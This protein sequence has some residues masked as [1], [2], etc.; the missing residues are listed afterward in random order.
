MA[1][2]AATGALTA[3]ALSGPLSGSGTA[4]GHVDAP[5]SV[6]D[7]AADLTDVYAFTSP[8]NHDT[9]TLVAS[10]RPFQLPATAGNA[11]VDYPF[12]NG[13][14]YEIHTDAD[15]DG[16]ADTTY[17]WT[18]RTKDSR[19]PFPP[20]PKVGPEPV[21]SLSSSSLRVRQTYTLE[22]VRAGK[23]EKL[24]S[25]TAAPTHAGRFLMPNYAG[26]R[27]QA[28][29]KLPGGGQTV[30]AQS[31]DAFKANTQAFGLYTVGT[32]GPVPKWMPDA[33]PLSEMNVS[34]LVLQVPKSEVAL[35]GDPQRNPVVGVWSTVSRPG[36]DLSRS[37]A[38]QAPAFRQISRQGIPH[39]AFG[40]YG[41]TIGLQRGNGPEDRFQHRTPAEDQDAKG[42]LDTTLDPVPPRKIAEAQNFPAPAAPRNDIQALFLKGIGADNGA[43][44]GYDLNSHAMNA[45]ADAD[46]IALAEELRLNLTTPVT[47]KPDPDGVLAGDKQGFP[48]G[49]RMN[50]NIDGPL[51]RMLMGEP[52]GRSAE[53]L[54]PKPIADLQPADAKDT[55]P[56]V[57]TP[58][59]FL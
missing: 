41:T 28:V 22:R 39:V 14:R 12:A 56:Y 13:A 34:S 32:A 4:G 46:R 55:F 21:T 38:R 51:I 30:A 54:L 52:G 23:A 26:L 44:F 1:M 16:A 6:K 47:A 35:K 42:F 33:N 25:G 9:V 19:P 11:V 57:N 17:R 48:N 43:K 40:L 59:A 49:R 50:D 24:V 10:V 5:S 7:T 3:A 27:S 18:F 15:G 31:A 53:G 36:A 8:D 20:L 29:E 37:L 58:H 45:D 2:L